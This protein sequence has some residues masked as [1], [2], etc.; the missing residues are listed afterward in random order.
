MVV[1]GFRSFNVLVPPCPNQP[2]RSPFVLLLSNPF[3]SEP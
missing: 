1:G 3:L 2:S